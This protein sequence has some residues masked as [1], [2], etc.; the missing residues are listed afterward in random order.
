M[1]GRKLLQRRQGPK[2]DE[3]PPQTAAG[4]EIPTLLV[5]DFNTHSCTWSPLGITPSTWANTLEEWAAVNTLELLT[6]PGT[7][8]RRGQSAQNQRDSTLDLAWRNFSAQVRGTFQGAMIDWPGSFG[9]DHALIRTLA[10]TLYQVRGQKSDHT[11]RFDT[12]LDQEGWTEWHSI[13][14]DHSPI[15]RGWLNT[16]E[17]VDTIIN[18]IYAAFNRACQA[19]M[20]HKGNNSA[21]SSR[22]WTSECKAASLALK[23]A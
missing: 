8:T 21:H 14:Q 3:D 17:E 2:H 6:I 13:M 15:V 19:T 9:S 4:D 11:N 5:G 16:K 12:D 10:C 18:L 23:E 20:K 22:W 7:P 1:A